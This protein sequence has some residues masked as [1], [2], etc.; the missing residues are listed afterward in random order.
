MPTAHSAFRTLPFLTQI[1]LVWDEG[2]HLAT[3]YEGSDT[4]V[5]YHMQ[6]EFFVEMFYNHVD[7]VLQEKL[8]TFVSPAFLEPYA[9]SIEL[10][11][12]TRK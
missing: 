12:L 10:D 9:A 8:R 4:L 6:G 2:H 3:R 7:N 1:E 11:D 5:L